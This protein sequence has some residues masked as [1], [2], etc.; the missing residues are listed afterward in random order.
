MKLYV[1]AF[2][3]IIF[4]IFILNKIICYVRKKLYGIKVINSYSK[5]LYILKTIDEETLVLFDIDNTLIS[6]SNIFA[7]KTLVPWNLKFLMVLWYPRL[8]K[9][10]YFELIYSLLWKESERILIEPFIPEFIDALKKKDAKVLALSQ[11]VFRILRS[12][13]RYA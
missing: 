12:Y 3:S 9:S 2:L 4:F 8:I 6:S 11:Y 13:S 5:V 10:N 1:Y 7:R